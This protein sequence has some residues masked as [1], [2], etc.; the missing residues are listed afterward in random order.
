MRRT[1]VSIK[2]KTYNYD[3]IKLEGDKVVDRVTYTSTE[4]PRTDMLMAKYPGYIL[5]D[6]FARVETKTYTMTIGDFLKAAL[7]V[8]DNNNEE[9]NTNG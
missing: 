8:E 3:L 1:H 7:V 2:V 4:T 5:L 6:H 9:E